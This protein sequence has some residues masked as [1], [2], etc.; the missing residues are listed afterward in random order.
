MTFKR[1]LGILVLSLKKNGFQ[2]AEWLKKH[3]VFA[4]MGEYCFWQPR[5]I[6]PE[7]KLIKLH[8]NVVIAS[9]VLSI[10]H[11]V[12][13]HVFKRIEPE[14]E[15]PTKFGAIEIGNNVF[16]G[17]RCI[18]LPNTKI[19]DNVIIGA[20]S[21]VTGRIVGG[22]V[23]AGAPAERIGDFDKVMKSRESMLR[24]GA[25]KQEYFKAFWKEFNFQYDETEDL[26]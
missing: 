19:E 5:N 25:S 16:I 24:N 21:I 12:M 10:N 26:L 15:F 20:G 7:S 22:G 11:D 6:P 8:D 14:F 13:H 2:R 18:V 23:Y 1:M 17:S 4:Q 9:E 3:D